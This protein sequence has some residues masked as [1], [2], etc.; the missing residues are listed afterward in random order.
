MRA[1]STWSVRGQGTRKRRTN[2][3]GRSG[4][5]ASLAV[6][7]L[8][9]L[10]P[11]ASAHASASAN[12]QTGFAGTGSLAGTPFGFWG[13]CQFF[14]TT[15]GT[16]GDCSIAQY[17]HI[18]GQSIQCQTQ[19][20]IAGWTTGPGLF[21]A[22]A[23]LPDFVITAGTVTVHPAAQ[24]FACATFLNQAGFNLTAVGPG[25]LVVSGP[26]DAGIPF[27]A[28]HYSYNGLSLG[29]VSFTEFQVQVS[30]HP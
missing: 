24:T 12:W 6:L 29:P 20:Q 21:T 3:A 26:S 16:N 4:A 19:I 1:T 10:V 15:S 27:A 17:L 9:A 5:I 23:G 18:P 7:A 28:G 22:I 13:W 30:Q 14:G 11:V 25:M 2:V 8:V